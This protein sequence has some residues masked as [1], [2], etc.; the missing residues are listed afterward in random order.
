MPDKL[1]KLRSQLFNIITILNFDDQLDS[2]RQNIR[3]ALE[4]I[5]GSIVSEEWPKILYDLTGIF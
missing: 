3:N 1:I 4:M 2:Y 5:K